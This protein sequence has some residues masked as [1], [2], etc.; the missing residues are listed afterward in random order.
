V[1][2]GGPFSQPVHDQNSDEPVLLDPVVD[3]LA[4]FL[5]QAHAPLD[6]RAPPLAGPAGAGGRFG[7]E[8]VAAWG[9]REKKIKM[10]S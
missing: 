7:Y 8:V 2:L 9:E 6:V 5:Q 1:V 10:V 3:A 4:P